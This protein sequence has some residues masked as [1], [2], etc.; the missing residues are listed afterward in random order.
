MGCSHWK[1]VKFKVVSCRTGNADRAWLFEHRNNR[2]PSAEQ[3]L[4]R[5]GQLK[6][7]RPEPNGATPSGRLGTLFQ[8]VIL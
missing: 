5:I 6:L 1:T 3:L 4:Q 8:T 2:P 7:D